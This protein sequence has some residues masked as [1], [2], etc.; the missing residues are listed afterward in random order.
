VTDAKRYQVKPEW[1]AD[2]FD[3]LY[4]RELMEKAWAEISFAFKRLVVP[5]RDFGTML[6]HWNKIEQMKL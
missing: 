3:L 1:V 2:S 6:F 5:A 4:F